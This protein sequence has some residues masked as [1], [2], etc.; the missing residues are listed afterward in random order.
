MQKTAIAVLLLLAVATAS[1]VQMRDIPRLWKEWKQ[2]HNKIY[3]SVE[4]ELYRMMIF[5]ENLQ[6]VEQLSREHTKATFGATVFADLTLEEFQSLHLGFTKKTTE[7]AAPLYTPVKGAAPAAWDWTEHDAVTNVKNQGSCGSCWAFSAA[8]GLE[9]Q[10][11]IVNKQLLSLSPQQLVDCDTVDEGC[12]GGFIYTAFVWLQGHGGIESWDDY[13]YKGRQGACQ[14]NASKAVVQV[15][16]YQNVTGP[17]M[18]NALYNQGPLSV[19]FHAG[20][21]IQLYTGGIFDPASCSIDAN[22]AVLAVGYGETNGTAWWK[23]KN[24]WGITWGQRGYFQIVRGVNMCGIEDY[25]SV[26][27]V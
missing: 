9:G 27:Q 26:P 20:I 2:T 3:D 23:V 7:Q 18:V 16:G 8:G 24:S 11:A 1:Q 17:N 5:Q 14:F 19:A 4:V 15:T 6:H 25:T 22:H 13:P 10:N 12:N 21:G